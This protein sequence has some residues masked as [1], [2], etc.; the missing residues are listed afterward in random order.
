M[1]ERF[2]EAARAVVVDAQQQARQL[3][4]HEI[5]AEHL[6]IGVFTDRESVGGS[7]LRDLGLTYQR[8]AEEVAAL[9]AADG[10]ALRVLGIDLT[11]VRAR[12][13]A[14]F[15]RGALDQPRPRR[16]GLLSLAIRSNGG[17]LPFA[18]SAK[19]ALGLSLRQ[20]LRLQHSYISTDHIL[21]G[22][23]ARDRE[24]AARTLARLGVDPALVRDTVR[25]RL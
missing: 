15:G 24:P 8:L 3:N 13:E 17:Y 9:G 20:A 1:F 2:T 19:R 5:R 7:V 18:T 21:L 25:D 23:L 6:L 11:A 4:H 10:D 14:A 16:T 12:A 22:L